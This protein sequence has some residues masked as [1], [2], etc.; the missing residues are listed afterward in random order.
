MVASQRIDAVS[1]SRAQRLAARRNAADESLWV[2]LDAVKDPEVPV[3]SLWEL[4][5][6]QDVRYDGD[7][8]VVV[9]TPTYSGCP[10]QHSMEQNVRARLTEAGYTRVTIRQQL[11]PAWTSDWLSPAAQRALRE[12]GIAPPGLVVCPQCGSPH[13]SLISQFGST[14]C[15]ALYRCDDCREPFDHFKRI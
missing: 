6:L 9:L 14:A 15:K 11:S 3:L 8:V 13:T 7:E 10:A 5:V 2:L 1:A 4:G 12:Y